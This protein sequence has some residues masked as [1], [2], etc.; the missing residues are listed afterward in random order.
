ML[1][2]VWPLIFAL[3]LQLV[4]GSVWATQASHA[5]HCHE[6]LVQGASLD[7]PHASPT[8]DDTHRISIQADGHHCCTVG[9]G[10]GVQL[11]LPLLP[12][13]TPVSPSPHWASLM[14]RPDLRP[15]I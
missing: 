5:G 10:A 2:T 3:L 13:T 1:K 14:L 15:P 4:P 7:T 9:L 8:K 12:Q 6:I 11:L